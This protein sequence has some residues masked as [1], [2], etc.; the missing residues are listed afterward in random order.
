[1]F[2]FPLPFSGD[3]WTELDKDKKI[4]ADIELQV[5]STTSTQGV[6]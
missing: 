3:I 1:M 2:V 4:E 5:H 6:P